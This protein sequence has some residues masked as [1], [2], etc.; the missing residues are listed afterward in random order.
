MQKWIP[1][2]TDKQRNS[3]KVGDKITSK[4]YYSS[5]RFI[6]IIKIKCANGKNIDFYCSDNISWTIYLEDEWF[7]LKEI[8]SYEDPSYKDL[9]I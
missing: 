6:T 3:L 7:L 4:I 9:W 2:N 5:G 8:N 1:I